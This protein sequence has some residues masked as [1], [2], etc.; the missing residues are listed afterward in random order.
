MIGGQGGLPGRRLAAAALAVVLGLMVSACLLLPGKFTSSLDLRKD[1]RFTY[2]YAGEIRLLALSKLA[3]G[4]GRKAFAPEACTDD[5]M[6]E[7]PCTPAELAE[8][9]R[10]WDESQRAAADKARKDAEGMKAVL[11]GIDPSSPQAAEELAAR[12]RRQ[13]GWRSVVYKGDGL[14]LVDF[15]LSGRLDHDFAFPTIERFPMAN[16]F[17]QLS[18][19]ADGSVRVDAPGFGPSSGTNPFAAMMGMGMGGGMTEAGDKEAAPPSPAEGTFTLT[20]DGVVLA[21]NTDEGPQSYPAGQKLAWAVNTRSAGAPT[22]LI[23]LGN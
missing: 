23:R 4:G 10:N 11:G 1:G 16:A 7:R 21:N 9:R 13:V 6:K 3:Q 2:A 19:R 5:E 14:Y 22:A 20:T 15:A 12:L 18:R 8:Q 17:V